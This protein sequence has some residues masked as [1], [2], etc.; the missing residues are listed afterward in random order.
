MGRA[1]RSYGIEIAENVNATDDG[2]PYFVQVG[3][4]HAR[5]W[6]ANEATL[7]WGIELIN[8]YK[9]GNARIA[10]I[11]KGARNIIV[12]VLN[13]DGFDVTIQVRGR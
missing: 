9:A 12:P 1:A 2:R 5:E 6:P 11:V 13:V 4:H 7:E 8:G 3:T 10:G